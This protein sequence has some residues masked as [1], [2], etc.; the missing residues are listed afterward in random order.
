[1]ISPP[2]DVVKQTQT[3][4][5]RGGIGV[6]QPEFA[7][8]VS[9]VHSEEMGDGADLTCRYIFPVSIVLSPAR[10]LGGLRR[11]LPISLRRGRQD[12]HQLSHNVIGTLIRS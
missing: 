5:A 11:F 10:L 6:P 1:M 4:E 2:G 9:A 8:E 12:P 3:R 7:G